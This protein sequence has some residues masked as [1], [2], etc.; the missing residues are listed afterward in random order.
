MKVVRD[1]GKHPSCVD[2]Q[3]ATTRKLGSLGLG[4]REK[5]TKCPLA[6]NYYLLTPTHG[7]ME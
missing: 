4:A 6:P 3:I 1:Q 2:T 5:R 7:V